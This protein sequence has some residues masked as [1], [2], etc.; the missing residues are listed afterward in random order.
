MKCYIPSFSL[1]RNRFY[2]PPYVSLNQRISRKSLSDS[3]TPTPNLGNQA[4]DVRGRL[5]ILRLRVGTTM[6]NLCP[7]RRAETSGESDILCTMSLT[8]VQRHKNLKD[9]TILLPCM[10]VEVLYIVD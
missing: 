7:T 10:E 9:N 3:E 1:R 6:R 5:N 4:T 2:S 8:R